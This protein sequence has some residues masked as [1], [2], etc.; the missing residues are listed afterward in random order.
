MNAAWLTIIMLIGAI[1]FVA[2]PYGTQ[3]VVTQ[4][5]YLSI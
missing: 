1:L 2:L 5:V 3:N 4:G